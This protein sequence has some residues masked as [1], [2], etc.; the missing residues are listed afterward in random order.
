MLTFYH[1]H[2]TLASNSPLSISF[3]RLSEL[4]GG[5]LHLCNGL[6]ATPVGFSG[7]AVLLADGTESDLV[8]HKN[9]DGGAAFDLPDGGH[10]YVSNSEIGSYPDDLSGGVYALTF[11]GTNK[12]VGYNQLLSGTAYNCHGGETPWGSWISCEEYRDNGRCWQV[13]PTGVKAPARTAITG[14]SMDGTSSG[15]MFGQ[16]EAFA[17][18]ADNNKAYITNDDHPA[19]DVS[20]TFP[21]HTS[22]TY[23]G[24]IVRFSP[25]AT[26]L[27]CLAAESDADKW[28][29]LESGTVDYLKLTPAATGT[30]G[31]F[32]WVAD[33]SEANPELYAATEGAHVENGIF[34]F[35][36]IVN[37]ELVQ[38]DLAAM[39]YTMSAVP[40]WSE[41]DNLRVVDDVVYLCTDDDDNN[42]DALWRWD[43]TGASRMFYEI[44]HSYPAGVDFAQD[45]KIMYVSMYGHTTYQITRTDGLTFKDE[46]AAVTYEVNGGIAAGKT[47]E[48]IS[49]EYEAIKAAVD[50][51]ASAPAAGGSTPAAAPETAAA[52]EATA[53]GA[54]S[55][56]AAGTLVGILTSTLM[57]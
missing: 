49:A 27:A 39:T 3:R 42:G 52:P 50:A 46:P 19:K 26:A 17:W 36:T 8:Y 56:A 40:F 45:H 21:D 37:R 43:E 55:N 54:V 44:G 7:A 24:A 11:D 23:Q 15:E 18:D 34:T 38:L 1:V 5:V 53:S 33:K 9:N 48:E 35:S 13:D 30:G 2:S 14:Q 47:H 22:Q 51:E 20:S 57:F 28:C 4:T 32:E 16:W 10:I 41:P 31:T 12:A 6:Q 29:V 25:D